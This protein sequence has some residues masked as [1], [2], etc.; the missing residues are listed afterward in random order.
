MSAMDRLYSI[1]NPTIQKSVN[2]DDSLYQK[3]IFLSQNKYDATISELINVCI[4]QYAE[5]NNPQ[6]Y[7][8]PDDESVT[9]RSIM[10]REDNLKWL[11]QTNKKTGISVTRLLNAALKNFIESL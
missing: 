11:R 10:I 8:K 2:I 9:Y 5:K 3:L 7:K 1:N 6:Y 4:E